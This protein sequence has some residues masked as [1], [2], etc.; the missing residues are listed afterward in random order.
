MLGTILI[1]RKS[2]RPWGAFAAGLLGCALIL[3]A[4]SSTAFANHLEHASRDRLEKIRETRLKEFPERFG[5]IKIAP[6]PTPRKLP[7]ADVDLADDVYNNI[8]GSSIQSFLYWD[9]KA[10][11]HDLSRQRIDNDT[12]VWSFSIA[13]SIVGYLAGR[14]LCAG[15]I[16]SLDDPMKKYAPVLDGL[17]YGNVKIRHALDMSSGDWKLYPSG[18]SAPFAGTRVWKDYQFPILR[19]GVPT[20]AVMRKL[21]NPEP[22]ERRFAY[23]SGNPDAVAMALNAAVPGGL[24]KFAS[25]TLAKDAGFEH[26]SMFLADKEGTPLAFAFFYATRMDWLRAGIHVGEQAKAPGCMGDYLR[27]AVTEA[28]PTNTPPRSPYRRYGKFFWGGYK[29][30]DRNF[31]MM[32]GHG[33]QRLYVDFDGGRVLHILSI[34]RDYNIGMMVERVFL[35]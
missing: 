3:P 19:D 34:R 32:A 6:S 24:G 22:S 13:K 29:W 30:S 25:E 35:Q 8:V 9:G 27:S 12:P 2:R 33:G 20:L 4:A 17:F 11:R 21:G 18:G 16:E 1:D 28:V 14:A 7:E 10:I 23:R 15:H 26:P 5:N 31:V